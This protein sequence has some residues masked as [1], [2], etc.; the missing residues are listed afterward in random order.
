M[1]S[2]VVNQRSGR[3]AFP[4]RSQALNRAAPPLHNRPR[5]PVPSLRINLRVNH[6]SLQV[7]NPLP[8]LLRVLALRRRISLMP[9]PRNSRCLSPPLSLPANPVGSHHEYHR[10]NLRCIPAINR[11]GHPRRALVKAPLR[12]HLSILRA[13]QR[14]LLLCSLRQFHLLSLPV[15]PLLPLPAFRQ[16]NQVNNPL[17]NLL[18]S[19]PNSRVYTQVS[20]R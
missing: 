20:S 6:Q 19:Q 2:P 13:N 12:S 10:S 17:A 1:C 15:H 4:A 18:S 8:G 3:P 9:R 7:V 14:T 5:R 16:R 11:S